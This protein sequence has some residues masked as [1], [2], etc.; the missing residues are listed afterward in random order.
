MSQLGGGSDG[1]DKAKLAASALLTLPGVPFL[2][3]GEEIGMT[4]QKPDEMIRTPMQ[5]DATEDAGFTDGTPWEP[6]N[7]DHT[8]VNVAAQQDDPESLL[9][10]YRT[11]LADPTGASR[12]QPGQPAGP[13][14]HLPGR[15][16]HPAPDPRRQRHG[17]RDAQ[18]RIHPGDPDAPS[19]R[20][21]PASPPAPWSPP[22]SSQV[23][24]QLICR[25]TP[26]ARSPATCP[27]TPWTRARRPSCTC[28]P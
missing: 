20:A 19:A 11:L 5:W 6:V 3:Y 10:H 28:E 16:R 2:Y 18:L 23:T 25:L 21:P 13:R 8:T 7:A 24:A 22:T 27:S 26:R 15:A 4:G 17:A 1:P 9:N 12:A 14:Q